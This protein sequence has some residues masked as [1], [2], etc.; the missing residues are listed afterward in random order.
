MVSEEN[1]R[2]QDRIRE[3]ET[4]LN[5][6][7]KDN[8]SKEN[9]QQLERQPLRVVNQNGSQPL[10]VVNQNGNGKPKPIGVLDETT[11]N[12]K[13][14][15]VNEKEMPK[16]NGMT[17]NRTQKQVPEKPKPNGMTGNRT[18]KQ[19]PEKPNGMTGNR[20]QKRNPKKK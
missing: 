15:F 2:L 9:H 5:S 3:L 20:T 10:L 14:K 18:Q 4:A 1:V 6:V 7:K 16:P 8:E 17:G 12:E 13:P 11:E 19:V